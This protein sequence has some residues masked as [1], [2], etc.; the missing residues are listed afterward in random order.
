MSARRWCGVVAA[1][2]GLL[3]ALLC[4]GQPRP[5]AAAPT[6]QG[7]PPLPATFWGAV[8]LRGAPVAAGL[9]ISAT[10]GGVAYG[11]TTTQPVDGQSLYGL[12]VPA[13]DPATPAIEGGRSGEVVAFFVAGQPATPTGNWQG[14]RSQRLDLAIA[15]LPGTSDLDGDGTT[16]IRDVQIAAGHFG[17]SGSAAPGDVDCNGY[18]DAADLTRLAAAW[19]ASASP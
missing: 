1:L 17:A 10:I 3:A 13:D 18:V 2:L 14:G 4:V 5:L 15:C 8:T 6:R 12:D 11:W 19:Q 7:P 16:T 9:P